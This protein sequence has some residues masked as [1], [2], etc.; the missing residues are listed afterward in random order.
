MRNTS[1]S[2]RNLW[3]GTSVLAL[4]AG[5]VFY[6][7]T[8]WPLSGGQAAGTIVPAERYRVEQVSSSD[9]KLGDKSV[10]DVMQTDSFQEMSNQSQ[11]SQAAS[12]SAHQAS[13][14]ARAVAISASVAWRPSV[15]RSP[16]YTR[17]DS[18]FSSLRDS[19]S[20]TTL[21]PLRRRL[22]QSAWAETFQ[23]RTSPSNECAEGPRPVYDS[24]DQYDELCLERRPGGAKFETS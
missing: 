13:S 1:F 4:A 17:S 14:Q 19:D 24:P 12:Q 16:R 5:G 22:S 21:S 9:V 11:T 15:V 18:R 7:A 8:G 20:A 3:I 2:K 23:L 10:A 6:V